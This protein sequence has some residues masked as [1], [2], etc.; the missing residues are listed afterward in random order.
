MEPPLFGA[1]QRPPVRPRPL[2]LAGSVALHALGLTLAL[3]IPAT[4]RDD[5]IRQEDYRVLPAPDRKII[6]Y[7]LDNRLPD[8]SVS[9]RTGL[10][11]PKPRQRSTK[12]AMQASMVEAPP[13]DQLIWQPSAQQLIKESVEL[14]NVA[15]FRPPPPPEAQPAAPP[16]PP[17]PE[18]EPVVESP[19]ATQPR[20]PPPRK[21]VP[22]PETGRPKTAPL[23]LA[24]P[25][26][27]GTVRGAS[28][29]GEMAVVV[30]GINPS[31]KDLP[32]M[33]EAS[34]PATVSVGPNAGRGSGGGVPEASGIEGL[35]VITRG[36]G[37]TPPPRSLFVA[38][39]LMFSRESIDQR[40][41]AIA[42]P[43]RLAMLP[44]AAKQHFG[45]RAV[46]L[47]FLDRLND[48][49]Y[50]SEVLMWFA[51]REKSARGGRTMHA[52][53]PFRQKDPFSARSKAAV[54]LKGLIRL[55]AVVGADGFVTDV[56]VLGGP[57]DQVN[58]M[59]AA[60]VASWTFV[61]AL[62]GGERIAVDVLLDI[63]LALRAT[64]DPAQRSDQ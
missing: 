16:A 47:V 59:M 44:P 37:N 15:A 14:P 40:R 31:M 54:A 39:T 9:N 7:K 38:Q 21:F 33:P 18:P 41:T 12:M 1:L 6:Y 3:A 17:A 56:R 60:A 4:N 24:E 64:L 36:S 43:V 48:V 22:P 29:L 55:A 63:P 34:R 26:F 46:Y 30:A 35:E 2:S 8:L 20:R 25:P 58:E 42:V 49:H 61:P 5:L 50:S 13:A 45:E 57:D 23:E 32:E 51:A 62:R 19:L 11:L 28:D 27:T 10:E 52:P 53:V